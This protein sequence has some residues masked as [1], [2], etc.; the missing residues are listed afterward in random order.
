MVGIMQMNH[1]TMESRNHPL[2]HRDNLLIVELNF[3]Q[4]NL[5]FLRTAAFSEAALM[6]NACLEKFQ[7]LKTLNK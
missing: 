5:F 3:R 7:Y 2:R 4:D 6:T 1:S